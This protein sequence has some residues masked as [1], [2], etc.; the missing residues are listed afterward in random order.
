VQAFVLSH[1]V[2]M[3]SSSKS[4][5]ALPA[6]TSVALKC[7]VEELVYRIITIFHCSGRYVRSAGHCALALE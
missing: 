5:G 3:G 6:P 1:G 2:C 4:W 7:R